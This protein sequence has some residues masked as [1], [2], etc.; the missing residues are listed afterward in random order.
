LYVAILLYI[1]AS[2]W[3]NKDFNKRTATQEERTKDCRDQQDSPNIFNDCT[4]WPKK[5]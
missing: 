3:W 4:G 2:V 1:A 5:I